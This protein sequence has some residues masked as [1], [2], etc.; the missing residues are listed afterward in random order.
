[1]RYLE[2]RLA[3]VPYEEGKEV[4][5]AWLAD[6]GFESFVEE[7]P[8]LKAYIPEE[9]FDSTCFRE[10][11]EQLE[12]SFQVS[13][14][15]EV[16][17]ERNWNEEWEMSYEDVIVDEEVRVRAPFHEADERFKYDLEIE[18]RM[19]FGT[20]H[21]DTTRQML[22]VLSE[23]KVSGLSVLDMGCGTG[24]IAILAAL[25]GAVSVTAIDNDEWAWQNSLDNV[26]RNGVT[27]EAV[28][29]G[30]ASLLRGKSWDLIMA[31]INRNILLQDMSLYVEALEPSGE[32]WMSGFYEEDLPQIRGEAERLGLTYL[33]SRASNRWVVAGFK[34]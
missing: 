14:E 12:Q 11:L 31:N 29:L 19:S 26:K 1:M 17:E 3:I 32:L 23:K 15:T 28:L 5:I 4:A 24:V 20:A 8:L 2:C 22:A 7:S 21:H 6:V 25:K 33:S 27:L 16:I 9:E 34:K 18:P 10:V 13:W 30:D